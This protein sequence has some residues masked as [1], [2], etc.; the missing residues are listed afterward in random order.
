MFG[1]D[2]TSIA[3]VPFGA[4][5]QDRP[6]PTASQPE[7]EARQGKRAFL[8]RTNRRRF[9]CLQAAAEAVELLPD[10]GEAVHLVM[11]GTYDLMHLLIALLQRFE[12][13]ADTMRVATLSLSS[14]NVAEMAALLDA[15]TIRR[16]D[17]LTSDFHC[18]HDKDIFGELVKELATQRGQR[19]GAARSHCKIVTL[20]LDDGRRY[21]LHG[22]PNLRTNK[23]LEQVCIEQSASLW[24]FYDAWIADMVSKNEIHE[25]GDPET[26]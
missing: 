3:P 18:K 23:N 21:V 14:R 24:S 6:T 2:F 15:G 9:A 11:S 16:L 26:G 12:A 8:S 25:S 17:V 4:M 10:D 22:S 19:V 7:G 5:V 20:A 1:P 13:P